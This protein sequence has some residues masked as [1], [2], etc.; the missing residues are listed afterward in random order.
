MNA[1]ECDSWIPTVMGKCDSWVPTAMGIHQLTC[2][3]IHNPHIHNP[4][5]YGFI[6][7]EQVFLHYYQHPDLLGEEGGLPQLVPDTQHMLHVLPASP[8]QF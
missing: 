6:H 1:M 8:S 7:L 3:T 5:F 4:Q 2:S